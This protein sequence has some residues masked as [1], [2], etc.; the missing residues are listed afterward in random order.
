MAANNQQSDDAKLQRE[1]LRAFLAG[2]APE[3]FAE[4]WDTQPGL[5]MGLSADSIRFGTGMVLQ[6]RL[7]LLEC[8]NDAQLLTLEPAD[9]L[10]FLQSQDAKIRQ[11][12][13]RVA[14]KIGKGSQ[15]P[16]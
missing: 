7:G 6:C 13:V 5:A 14:G 2:L 1:A 10:P 4:I 16:E 15:E 12:G 3:A 9:L 8:A 11:I